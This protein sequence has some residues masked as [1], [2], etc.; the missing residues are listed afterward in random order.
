MCVCVWLQP[1]VTDRLGQLQLRKDTENA[2][3]AW[4]WGLGLGLKRGRL[5]FFS[6]SLGTLDIFDHASEQF[7]KSKFIY[8]FIF[9]CVGSSLLRV[10]FLFAVASLVAEHGP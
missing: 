1:L 5:D 2:N 3:R 8:L 6:I 10:G 9:G 7:L 4:H